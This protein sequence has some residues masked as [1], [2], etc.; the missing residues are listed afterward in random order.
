M[1]TLIVAKTSNNCIGDKNS[2]PWVLKDDMM[3]FKEKT[4]KFIRKM[5]KMTNIEIDFLKIFNFEELFINFSINLTI[6]QDLLII[7]NPFD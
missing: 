6:F 3:F 2:L 1:L 5:T 4:I 7:W